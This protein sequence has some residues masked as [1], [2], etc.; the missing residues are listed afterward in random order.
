MQMQR[1]FFIL[2]VLVCALE[3]SAQIG[4]GQWRMHISPKKAVSVTQGNGSVYVALSKGL[5]EYDLTAGEITRRTAADYLSDNELTDVYY[6]SPRKRVYIGYANGNLDVLENERIM[7][8]NAINVAQLTGSKR[9]NRIE[10][11]GNEVYLATGFGIV[12]MNDQKLEVKD[13]YYPSAGNQP[14]IDLA[15]TADSI[16]ALTRTSL[17]VGALNNPFLADPAQWRIASYVPNYSATGDY[18]SIT[19]FGNKLF[20]CYNDEVYN[21][22]TLFQL[23][24]NTFEWNPFLVDN[25]LNFIS[26]ADDKMLVSAE[27][28]LIIY[29]QDLSQNQTIFQYSHGSFP[30]CVDATF[31]DGNYYIADRSSGLVKTP[32]AFSSQQIL[33]PGPDNNFSYRVDWQRGKLAVAG[34][35][36]DRAGY[37]FMGEEWTSTNIFQQT[38]T[39]GKFIP[40]FLSTTANPRNTDQVAFG[41]FSELPLVITGDGIQIADTIS[42]YNSLLEV[43][44]DAATSGLNWSEV[45][46]ME[47]D[48]QGNLWVANS[49]CQRPLKVYTEGGAWYDFDLGSTSRNKFTRRIAVDSEGVKWLAIDGA[50]VYAFDDN[51]TI[52]DPSDD[53]YRLMNSNE[54]AGNLPTTTVEALAVDLDNNIW[55]GTPEGLRVLYNSRGVFDA[56][57][58]NYNFQRLLIEFGEN[59]EIVLGS[60]H[61]TDIEIDGAN[62]KWIGTA[63]SGVFLFSSDGLT[64]IENFTAENSPL[65]TNT[66]LDMTINEKTGEIYF[67]TDQGMISYRSDASTGDNQ[68]TNVRVFPNPVYPNY[69]GPI[70]IQ[71][72]ASNSEVKITDVAGNLVFR[73]ASN[74][75]TATWDG[76]TLQGQRATTGVYLIWT[77]VDIEGGKGRKVGKVVFIN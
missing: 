19:S 31:V 25:E 55:V 77:S 56:S 20:L 22:D 39:Q 40:G 23:D 14:I 74:G 9:I 52:D 6:H 4:T 26:L 60:T 47:Y 44:F 71:G 72:I 11:R 76:R 35:P 16:Y 5:L 2:F 17:F 7:N 54:N 24:P 8:I 68:Y 50:G 3:S 66:I 42:T 62:R 21:G 13:T 45:T 33:F 69:F 49:G 1:Y 37:T 51:G 15:F 32:N 18:K 46:D 58:G 61:I 28:G 27:G 30:N 73:T 34:G 70:T 75:G 48:N 63:N 12:V 65:L 36:G 67:V 41:S 43:R 59:V 53:R 38:L 10:A 29:N 57:P 64:L